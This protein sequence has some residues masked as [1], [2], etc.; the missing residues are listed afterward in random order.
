MI[1]IATIFVAILSTVFAHHFLWLY[2][3]FGF[4]GCFTASLY[5]SVRPIRM[6]VWKKPACRGRFTGDYCVRRRIIDRPDCDIVPTIAGPLAFFYTI[7]VLF[8]IYTVFTMGRVSIRPAVPLDEQS[9][10]VSTPARLTSMTANM[11]TAATKDSI[12]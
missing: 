9:D 7:S 8:M 6:T 3:L 11:V 4:L 12:D 2:I 10:F 5:R 1:C